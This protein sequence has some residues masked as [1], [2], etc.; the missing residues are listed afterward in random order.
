MNPRRYSQIERA[1]QIL[2]KSGSV[3]ILKEDHY[4]LFLFKKT[5][6]IVAALYVITGMFPD[7]EPL[8]WSIREC[9]ILCMKHTLS[10]K[11]RSTVH[12]KEFPSDTL[13]EIARLLSLLDLAHIADLISPMNFSVVKRELEIISATIEGKWRVAS[14]PASKPFFD[15]SFFGVTGSIFSDTR[16]KRD[17]APMAVPFPPTSKE[18]QNSSLLH[19][20]T[21]FENLK[22]NQYSYKGHK[23][24][25]DSVL[26]EKREVEHPKT[27]IVINKG[28]RKH[29]HSDE[30]REERKH[31]IFSVLKE[32]KSAMIK[33]FSSVIGGCSEKTIQRLLNDMVRDTVLKRE[34]DRR[35]SRYSISDKSS[36]GLQPVSNL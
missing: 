11:E 24:I 17:E 9:G 12:S 29:K 16:G 27:L 6:R 18:K 7:A 28:Q 19:S 32:K 34:G 31:N 13:S 23:N 4:L 8:K 22:K 3:D 33:D 36:N 1:L 20:F 26:Y 14:P 25:K 21:D 5:E 35:W 10:F 15:E 30:L 2:D